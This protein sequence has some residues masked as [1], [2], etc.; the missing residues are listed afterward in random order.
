MQ[1]ERKVR[2]CLQAGDPSSAHELLAAPEVALSRFHVFKDLALKDGVLEGVLAAPFVLIGEVRFPFR[3]RFSLHGSEAELTPLPQQ[4]DGETYAELAGVARASEDRVCYEARVVLQLNLPEGEKWGGRA[5]R[6]MAE[7]AF[8][9][10]LTR[11]LNE[12]A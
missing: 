12:I 3:S 9:R 4:G 6:K 5:F 10:T 7:A 11:T 1:L 2:F 8:E